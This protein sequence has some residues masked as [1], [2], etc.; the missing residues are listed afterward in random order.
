MAAGEGLLLDTQVG[1]A[2]NA[3]KEVDVIVHERRQWKR[4]LGYEFTSRCG[5]KAEYSNFPAGFEPSGPGDAA[6]PRSNLQK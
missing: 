3:S 5:I 4:C 2:F 1:P 6:R